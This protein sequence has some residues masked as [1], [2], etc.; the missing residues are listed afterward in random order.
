MDTRRHTAGH[1][2]ASPTARSASAPLRSPMRLFATPHRAARTGSSRILAISCL[3]LSAV[4]CAASLAWMLAAPPASVLSQDMHASGTPLQQIDHHLLTGAMGAL[5]GM[6]LGLGGLLFWP[7]GTGIRLPKEPTPPS[8]YDNV[9]GLPTKRLFLALLNQALA[10][11]H[12]TGRIVAVLVAELGEYRPSPTSPS[13]PNMTLLARVQ[14]ARIKSALESH[15]AVARL[16]DRTFA[17]LIDNIVSPERVAALAKKIQSTMSLPLMIEGQ[18][19][20]L[21][22]R[23]G[24]AAAP[25]DGTEGEALLETASRILSDSQDPDSTI[26]FASDLSAPSS[27]THRT[28]AFVSRPGT[29]T[30]ARSR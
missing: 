4:I 2:D 26:R 16:G 24:G 7:T 10:R 18:E 8:T 1:A 19:I 20:L 5:I 12:T 29:S 23:I 27:S 15:D 14:A 22:C 28:A 30:L 11:S 3:G 6:G 13:I 17:V 9:T 25:A 21:S